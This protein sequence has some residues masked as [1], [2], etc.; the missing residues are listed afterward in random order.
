MKIQSIKNWVMAVFLTSLSNIG[1]TQTEC[2]D[3]SGY[4]DVYL[5]FIST[6]DVSFPA[7]SIFITTTSG[8]ISYVKLGDFDIYQ[9]ING[10]TLGYIGDI[11]IDVS[12]PQCSDKIL[13]FSVDTLSELTVDDEPVFTA[14]NTIGTY[15]GMNFTASHPANSPYTIQGQFNLVKLFSAQNRLYDVCLTCIGAGL[16]DGDLSGTK[17]YPNPVMEQ[18]VVSSETP[19][20]YA[21]LRSVNGNVCWEHHGGQATVHIPLQSLQA[22]SYVLEVKHGAH[23]YRRSVVKM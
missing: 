1:L 23:M 3:L 19:W 10:D 7:G 5:D 13:T 22:G 9:T 6:D 2:V 16:T 14:G 8:N 18:L 17:V 20:E 11:G 12:Y 4:T 21:T 15:N